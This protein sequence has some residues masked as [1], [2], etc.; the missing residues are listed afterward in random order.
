[1]C[2]YIVEVEQ[3]QCG[4]NGQCR[5]TIAPPFADDQ[6]ETFKCE[7][8][9]FISQQ[10]SVVL[11]HGKLDDSI[12]KIVPIFPTWAQTF[13]SKIDAENL[14]EIR[15]HCPPILTCINRSYSNAYNLG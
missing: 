8:C 3:I 11:Q 9:S 7:Y 13:S 4:F 2:F 10:S 12:G 15:K 5:C 6:V 14:D 1:M